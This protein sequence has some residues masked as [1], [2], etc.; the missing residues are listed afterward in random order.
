MTVVETKPDESVKLKVDFVKPFEG[1][2]SSEFGFKPEGGGTAVTW[3]MAG[4][5]DSF[6]A[7]AICLVMNGKKMIGG[8]MEKG[9]AQLKS[10]AES[11]ASASVN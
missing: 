7:K 3:S 2:S 4:S 5:N 1:T 10:V 6:V 9:L 8:E 11:S